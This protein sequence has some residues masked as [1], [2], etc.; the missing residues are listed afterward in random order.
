MHRQDRPL[1]PLKRLSSR[2]V[3]A[4]SLNLICRSWLRLGLA[5]KICALIYLSCNQVYRCSVIQ[6]V[7]PSAE[8]KTCCNNSPAPL[9]CKRVLCLQRLGGY[10]SAALHMAYSYY[11]ALFGADVSTIDRDASKGKH[12]RHC[13]GLSCSIGSRLSAIDILSIKFVVLLLLVSDCCLASILS[14]LRTSGFIEELCR[15]YRLQA[16]HALTIMSLEETS[17]FLRGQRSPA[18]FV[19]ARSQEK[20]FSQLLCNLYVGQT[21][22]SEKGSRFDGL[23]QNQRSV[24][25]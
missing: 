24:F 14:T 17:G 1:V 16:P 9:N 21:I 10:N 18:N 7:D 20:Y 5:P 4:T 11:K 2:S 13:S 15:E 25:C 8:I 12:R 23:V 6:S 19:L 3:P 22:C